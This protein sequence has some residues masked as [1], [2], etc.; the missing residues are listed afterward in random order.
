MFFFLIIVIILALII[1]SAKR[2]R[3][4]PRNPGLWYGIPVAA[5]IPLVD[6]SNKGV[7]TAFVVVLPWLLIFL[8]LYEDNEA[9]LFGL[10]ISIAFVIR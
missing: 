7:Q 6:F 10:I 3:N 9:V 5:L 2:L 1:K 4:F 8:L